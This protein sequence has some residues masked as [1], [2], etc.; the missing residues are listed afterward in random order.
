MIGDGARTYPDGKPFASA[1]GAGNG[2]PDEQQES[3]DSI[4]LGV[5]EL[6][7]FVHRHG[8]IHYRYEYS[9]LAQEG[10]ARQQDYQRD[11]PESYQCEVSVKATFGAL[12]VSGRID[13]WDPAAT[14][15][16]EIKTTRADARE[17]HARIGSVN[18]AQLKLYGA[19]LVLADPTLGPLR[20][21]LVY[22]HPDK[23]TETVI[24]ERLS[25]RELIDFFETTCAAYARWMAWTDSR[26][27]RRDER[28]RAAS[29]PHGKFRAG[30][31][32]VAKALFRG[33]RDAADWLVEAPTGSGKTI[34]SVFPAYK[35]MG[36]GHLDRVVFLT[37]RTTG[38]RAAEAAFRDAA[39]D[40]A[41]AVTI[42]AKERICFN[43][44]MPCDPDLCEFA[45]GY[46]DRM[47]AARRELLGGGVADRALV[48]Q[49]ARE[50]RVCPFELSLDTA[51]WADAV[52][53]DYNYVF[54]PVIR[55]KRLDNER[56]RRIGVIVDEAHQLGDRVRDMLG[57][58]LRRSVVKAAMAE[59]G[60]PPSLAK[61]LRS[62]D[63]ALAK[64]SKT[65][66]T[67]NAHE[68]REVAWPHSLARAIDRFLGAFAETLLEPDEFPAL[69]EAHFDLLRFRRAC[70]WAEEGAFHCLGNHSG[71]RFEV[72]IV[73]TV[74][75]RH[76]QEILAPFHGSA[77]LSGTLTPASVFQRIHGFGIE[78]DALSTSGLAFPEQLDVLL[79]PDLSTFYRDRQRTM[80]DLVRL[81]HGVSSATPGNILVAFPSFAY[82][83]AVADVFDHPRLRCQ[84]PDMGLTDRDD[85]IAWLNEP[86]A[87]RVAFVVM[88][89]VFAESVDYD[90]RAVRAVVAVGVGL[91][92]RSLRRDC[93]AA[94]SV[95]NDIAE[96]GF[97]IA[98]RQPAMTRVVQAVGRVARGDSRGVAVLVDSRFGDPAYQAFMPNWWQPRF[99]RARAAPGEVADFWAG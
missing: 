59:P 71:R 24:E 91:P 85:F 65:D 90:S 26:L 14:L 88:G 6:A 56:F 80:P 83:R 33:F 72:E 99:V 67:E 70:E 9:A 7:Q 15:V 37:S 58:R 63:R 8:D 20:L 18:S 5:K 22:L 55:L 4:R 84:E 29:F 49:V 31:R 69:S 51:A 98:Y 61:G 28:L 19:M 2:T 79:V 53:G 41:V 43:P 10:I 74:P 46:Y 66:G 11:R 16:E 60:I 87:D 54:D 86:D 78:S 35:A 27:S 34:A 23:P 77:R 40:A 21:R 47:P 3:A 42:T 57:M 39:G 96:D 75:G 93:I 50:H 82:A 64:L 68:E 12:V 89:G 95:A 48:E 13:G 97:E 94:D 62:V 17:L 76:I 81:I 92:P 32:G 30:Q 38:Q 1:S 36:Q 44:G 52:I 73:C 25:R 45:R